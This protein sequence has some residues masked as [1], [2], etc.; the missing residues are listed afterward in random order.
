VT[1]SLLIAP[2]Y[3][4]CHWLVVT[5]LNYES[6]EWIGNF[7]RLESSLSSYFPKTPL[8]S[9]A[10]LWTKPSTYELLEN[11]HDTQSHCNFKITFTITPLKHLHFLKAIYY[12]VHLLVLC[13]SNHKTDVETVVE[14][15]LDGRKFLEQ[16]SH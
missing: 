6:I 10:A 4:F 8:V 9:T 5:P 13:M 16:N 12:I 7:M 14:I 3:S 15:I 2:P 1:C 11:I